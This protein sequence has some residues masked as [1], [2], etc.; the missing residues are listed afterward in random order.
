MNSVA[1]VVSVQNVSYRYPTS[2]KPAISNINLEVKQSEFLGIIGPSEAGKTTLCL[3]LNGIIPHLIG[4]DFTGRVDVYGADTRSRRVCE[5]AENIGMVFEDP[6]TQ[7]FGLV[8]EE[9]VAFG[10]ENLR[11]PPHEIRGRIQEA[12]NITKLSGF[13]NRETFT[14]SGGQKQRTAI[15]STLAMKSSILVLDEPTTNLDPV[16]KLEVFSVIRSLKEQQ[17][18]TIIMTDHNTE[19][20]AMFADR[21]AVMYDGSIVREGTPNEIFRDIDLLD[22]IRVP[23]PEV[24]RLCAL[25]E[26]EGL[27]KPDDFTLTEE[28]LEKKLT[29]RFQ[30][31]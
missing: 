25:L 5:L 8:V 7:L 29:S 27:F 11:V 16:G 9:D 4:G 24:G 1:P 28:D 14:L 12:L 10:P 23:V 18:S 20:L 17:G 13:E 19:H 6:E 26:R 2:S 22:K 21:I 3:C 30:R 31:K 15:A